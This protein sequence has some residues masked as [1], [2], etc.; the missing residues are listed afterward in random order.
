MKQILQMRIVDNDTGNEIDKISALFDNRQNTFIGTKFK[1]IPLEFEVLHGLPEI[2]DTYVEG[3]NVEAWV[4]AHL[5]NVFRLFPIWESMQ[6]SETL[7][8]V[9]TYLVAIRRLAR[10]RSADTSPGDLVVKWRIKGNG[11]LISIQFWWEGALNEHH[12]H[13][14]RS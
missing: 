6:A 5:W 10:M 13:L 9:F 12:L 11:A 1:L 14:T 7:G 2:E 3:S 8:K 4:E